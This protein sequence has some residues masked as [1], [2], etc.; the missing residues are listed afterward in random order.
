MWSVFCVPN[1][2]NESY[3]YTLTRLMIPFDLANLNHLQ[4]Y[5]KCSKFLLA[6]IE[7]QES[8][9]STIVARKREQL[10][11]FCSIQR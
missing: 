11:L 5:T 2:M 1:L 10:L 4:S 3:R 6:M 7:L 8:R 9:E